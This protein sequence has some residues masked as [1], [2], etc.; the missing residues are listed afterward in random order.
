LNREKKKQKKIQNKANIRIGN[1]VKQKKT[2]INATK[3]WLRLKGALGGGPQNPKN[4]KGLNGGGRNR[5]K[6]HG[7]QEKGNYFSGT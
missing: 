3:P 6:N 5:R 1:P 7:N 4:E 2:T